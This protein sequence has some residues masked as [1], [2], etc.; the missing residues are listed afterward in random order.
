[1]LSRLGGVNGRPRRATRGR[2]YRASVATRP[3]SRPL[4]LEN[5]EVEELRTVD[6]P[7]DDHPDPTIRKTA[8]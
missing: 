5:V 8:R 2:P 1:M 4:S 3:G 7:D 6:H